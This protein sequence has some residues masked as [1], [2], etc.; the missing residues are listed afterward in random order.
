LGGG[1]PTGFFPVSFALTTMW[2]SFQYQK[3]IHDAYLVNVH[4]DMAELLHVDPANGCS[5]YTMLS[6]PIAVIRKSVKSL[7]DNK[8]YKKCESIDLSL[9]GL[10]NN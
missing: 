10:V 4:G 5:R 7:I 9:R 1:F 8:G 2:A 3:N 6:A